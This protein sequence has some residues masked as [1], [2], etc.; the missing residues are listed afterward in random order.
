MSKHRELF[1]IPFFLWTDEELAANVK[2]YDE[3]IKNEIYN[4]K[5]V[6]EDEKDPDYVKATLADKVN[7]YIGGFYE[8]NCLNPKPFLGL[9]LP[10]WSSLELCMTSTKHNEGMMWERDRRSS[11]GEYPLFVSE[12]ML[13]RRESN[14]KRNEQRKQE[15]EE[16]EKSELKKSSALKRKAEDEVEPERGQKKAKEEE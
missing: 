4:R 2:S 9:P 16:A 6:A 14:R 7:Y 3:G 11:M 5:C 12:E 1:R 8:G 10:M 15:R 13:K